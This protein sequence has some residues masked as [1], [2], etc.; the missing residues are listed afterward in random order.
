VGIHANAVQQNIALSSLTL[1]LEGDLNI[2][3]VWGTGHTGPKP[4]GFTAV[5]VRVKL[6]AAADEER[7]RK[8]VAHAV[9]WSP[10]TGSIRNPVP[11]DVK[12]V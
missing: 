7:L 2:T 3:S 12:L 1:E 10:V 9:E 8:L 6:D 5:R 11:V 4:V